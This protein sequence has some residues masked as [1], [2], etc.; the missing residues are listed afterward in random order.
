MKKLLG[1]FLTCYLGLA[2][3]TQSAPLYY[4]FDGTI[5]LITDDLG[6]IADA[7]LSLGSSISYTI[8]V[9]TERLA[10][11]TRVDGSVH[12]YPD[13]TPDYDYFFADLISGSEIDEVDGGS[14]NETFS[15]TEWNIGND[16]Y[17]STVA[18]LNVGSQDNNIMVHSAYQNFNEWDIGSEVFGVESAYGL[19][20]SSRDL[21]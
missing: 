18:L 5:G 6:I 13:T 4:S 14:H 12:T 17:N 16:L 8:L 10:T 2:G 20:C 1:L 7:G 3:N 19:N 9:D 11:A 15:V 21:I